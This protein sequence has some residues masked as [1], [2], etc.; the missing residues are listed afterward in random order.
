MMRHHRLLVGGA[1]LEHQ[2]IAH[3]REMQPIGPAVVADRLERIGFQEIVDR[4]RALVLDVGVGATDRALVER[5]LDQPAV[6][7]LYG[8]RL[9]SRIATER[10][11]AARPSASPS[12]MA[13]GPSAAS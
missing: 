12:A 11:W 4:D 8:H 7:P 9:L 10:A 3:H 2:P 6:G 1:H 5:D 13:A